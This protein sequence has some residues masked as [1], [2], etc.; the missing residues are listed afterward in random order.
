M[1]PAWSLP[2]AGA[3][4]CTEATS[5]D[6]VAGTPISVSAAVVAASWDC[7][8]CWALSLSTWAGV[9]LGGNRI[10]RGT[11]CSLE[12]SQPRRACSS[13]MRSLTLTVSRSSR[14]SVGNVGRPVIEITVAPETLPNVSYAGPG[15][16]ET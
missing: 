10:S 14:P 7:R 8:I 2:A 15:L 11:T 13:V 3:P 16:S 4:G 1:S 12:D 6:R 5:T 9:W